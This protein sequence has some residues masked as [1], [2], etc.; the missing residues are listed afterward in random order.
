MKKPGAQKRTPGDIVRIDLGD[1][2]HAYG[3]VLEDALFALY[4]GC[5]KDELPLSDICALKV[6]FQVPV[7]DKAVKLGRWTI[8][9]HAP[10]DALLLNPLPQYIQD[11]IRKDRFSIYHK[12]QIRPATR[13][14][15]VGLERAAVWD[16]THV[17]DRLRDHFA[18]RPN[19]W[20]ESLRIKL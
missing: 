7:M 18:G 20:V 8:V 17:E 11:P 6:L 15:V 2:T 4:D 9:G 16:P 3:R 19:K 1:K 5:F 14:E 13:E 12:G 10:L